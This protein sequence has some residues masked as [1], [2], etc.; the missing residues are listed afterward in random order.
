MAVTKQCAGCGEY[1]AGD[2]DGDYTCPRCRAAGTMR[3]RPMVRLD[4]QAVEATLEPHT[5][6]Q[7]A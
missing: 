7:A 2:F 1:F 5:N 3:R 4:G 6:G